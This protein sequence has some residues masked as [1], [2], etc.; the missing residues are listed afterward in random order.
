MQALGNDP[1][2]LDGV[3][4]SLSDM[5]PD[6]AYKQAGHLPIGTDTYMGGYNLS[7]ESF[8]DAYIPICKIKVLY[9]NIY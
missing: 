4:S 9:M 8:M 7:L 1:V 6:Q 5:L 3:T 2:C